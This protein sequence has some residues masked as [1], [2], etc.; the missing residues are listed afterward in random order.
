MKANMNGEQARHV[1]RRNLLG[2]QSCKLNDIVGTSWI[3]RTRY[4]CSFT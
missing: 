4:L 2:L 1:A 3:L